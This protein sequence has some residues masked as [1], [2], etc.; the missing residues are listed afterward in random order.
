MSPLLFNI[1][2]EKIMRDALN[3][4]EGEIGIGATVVTNLRY[5]DDRTLIAGTKEYLIEIME[6]VRKTREKAGL[7]PN[8]LKTKVM[9]T[10]DFGELAV[11]GKIVAVVT[12]FICLG[13]L[14]TRDG[15]CD[16]EIRRRI[17]MGKA[18]MGG[19]TTI[20]KDR[21]IKLG[22]KVK[23]VKALVFPIVLHGASGDLDD[24]KSR[25]EES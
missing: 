10:G 25:E 21:E 3:K 9:T 16:K 12:S 11:D 23:L 6:R 15:L 14:I 8:V 17:A 5:A 18:A 4:W 24:E 7:Y 20:W 19:L 2:A 13:A 22:T 1:Y